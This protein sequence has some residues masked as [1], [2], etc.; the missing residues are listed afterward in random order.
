MMASTRGHYGGQR[1]GGSGP[2]PAIARHCGVRWNQGPA[3]GLSWMPAC[4]LTADRGNH[5]ALT[6]FKQTANIFLTNLPVEVVRLA[7]G[8]ENAMA[9]MMSLLVDINRTNPI[10]DGVMNDYQ[11]KIDMISI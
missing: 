8:P 11:R 4:S 1:G 7:R 5:K 6:F 3:G 2:C 10:R 9:P